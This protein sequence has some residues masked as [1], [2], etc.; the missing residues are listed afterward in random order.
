MGTLRNGGNG[1]FIGK[2]GSFIVSSWKDIS[3]MKKLIVEQRAR[4]RISIC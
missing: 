1:T 4:T 2:A 3:Y